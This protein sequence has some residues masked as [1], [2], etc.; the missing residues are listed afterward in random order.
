MSAPLVLITGFLGA[1]K[2]TFLRE[3]L[4]LLEMRGLAPFVIINDY[5]NAKVDAATLAKEGRAVEPIT[6]SCIC[7]DS[8]LELLNV[9]LEIPPAAGRVVLIEANGTSDPV[10][11]IE[12]LLVNPELRQ[13]YEPILQVVVIDPQRWQ[14][15]RHHNE[16]ELLQAES[17]SHILI[18]REETTPAECLE[19]VVA[20]LRQKNPKAE[21]T[22]RFK[23]TNL[24]CNLTQ[25]SKKMETAG[26]KFLVERDGEG[27]ALGSAADCLFRSKVADHH[28][29]ADQVEHSQ[30][31]HHHGH[32]A[33][34]H[35]FVG[36]QIELPEPVSAIH[37]QRWLQSLPEDVLRAKGIATFSE[38][39]GRWYQFHRT[40]SFT[41]EAELYE[42]SQKPVVP[43]CAV[44]I[45]VHLDE[46]SI[47]KTLQKILE[48]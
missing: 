33:L 11:L 28:E 47:R 29:D 14:K 34:S 32:H 26:T 3:V 9:L 4:P 42:L 27:T 41:G 37:L 45:G 38:E 18:T 21:F 39:P 30:E 7:C 46:K 22:D 23:F 31:H 20:D 19:K 35:G 24:L 25:T 8:I 5:A 1:G 44:L 36:L 6:G 16:L 48:N 12:H 17:S 13:R 10:T 15:R 2:T 43:S 40:D